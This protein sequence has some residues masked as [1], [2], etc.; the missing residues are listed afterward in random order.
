MGGTVTPRTF[1]VGVVGVGK[2]SEQYLARIPRLPILRLAAVTDR[3]TARAD[4]VARGAGV[5]ALSFE[6]MLGRP[7]I[8]IVLDLTIPAAHAGIATAALSAGKHVYSEKPIALCSEDAARLVALAERHKVRLGTA[9]DTVLGAGVQTAWA[10]VREGRIGEIVGAAAAWSAPGHELWHP[11]PAF[12]Y[13]P[14]AGPLMDM[15]PYYLTSL[16]LM[17][18]PVAR[19]SGF[20][21]S[22]GRARVVETG[23]NAGRSLSVDPDV[24]THVIAM[25]EHSSGAT[26]SVQMSF[27]IWGSQLPPIGTAGTVSVPDPNEFSGPTMVYT[28]ASREWIEADAPMG[29]V[30]AGRGVGLAEMAH[31][32]ASGRPHR[33]TGELAAHVSEIMESITV[34]ARERRIVEVHSEPRIPE[35]V[36]AEQADEV[37]RAASGGEGRKPE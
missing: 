35:P 25:L 19:V 27:E 18:G 34:A 13:Q 37:F 22:S 31:S 7:D 32:I 10:A 1:G 36:S 29:Y 15:G 23:P 14:G 11:E 21:H 24:P 8:D 33:A 30:D 9:P 2:I 26:T 17:L 16:V 28:S 20:A 6:E 5:E 12:Y 3:D 4:A